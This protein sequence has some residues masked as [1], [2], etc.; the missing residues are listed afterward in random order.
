MPSNERKTTVTV[1]CVF[2]SHPEAMF[3]LC[4]F[5]FLQAAVCGAILVE[6]IKPQGSFVIVQ[7]CC[8]SAW[9][10]IGEHLLR[11]VKEAS[12]TVIILM[13]P[14]NGRTNIQTAAHHNLIIISVECGAHLFHFINQMKG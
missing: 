8:I 4:L 9:L 12:G 1:L 2:Y 3:G 13:M 7:R 6:E 11:E 5:S 14:I 10:G